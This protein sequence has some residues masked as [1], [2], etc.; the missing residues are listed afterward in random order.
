MKKILN[1]SSILLCLLLI[2]GCG[3]TVKANFLPSYL[4]TVYVETF[5]NGTDQPN[6][7]N[8]FRTKIISMIQ[9]E[10]SL[11]IVSQEDADAVLTGELADYYRHA[12]RYSNDDAVREYRLG[13]VASFKFFDKKNNKVIVK[14]NNLSGDTTFYLTGS[15]AASEDN[16]RIDA[17]ED[18]SRQMLN[19]ILTL[20]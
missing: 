4:K 5:H 18:L 3:Y 14:D 17:L 12:L 9:D 2:S 6:L 20:W 11:S 10:G 15:L 7:E 13:I 16:A 19:K 1:F 8:E